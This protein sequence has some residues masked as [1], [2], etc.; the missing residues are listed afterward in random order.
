VVAVDLHLSDAIVD[1]IGEGFDGAIR[2]AVLH[3]AAGRQSHA[4]MKRLAR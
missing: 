4:G 2:L 3:A 1:L